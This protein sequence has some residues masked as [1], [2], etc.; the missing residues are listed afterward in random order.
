LKELRKKQREQKLKEVEEAQQKDLEAQKIREWEEKFDEEQ[1]IKLKE[2]LIREEKMDQRERLRKAI[3]EQEDQ[4]LQEELFT[5][6]DAFDINQT[7]KN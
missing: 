6:L 1:K 7:K 2:E 5:K 3:R 4:T